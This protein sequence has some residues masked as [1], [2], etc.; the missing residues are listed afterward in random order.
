VLRLVK[1]NWSASTCAQA[2]REFRY[3]AGYELRSRYRVSTDLCVVRIQ[4]ARLDMIY[5]ICNKI[6]HVMYPID[7]TICRD[8]RRYRDV[9]LRPFPATI[10]VQPIHLPAPCSVQAGWIRNYLLELS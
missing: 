10:Y 1:V 6:L 3:G 2:R 5:H 4:T 8:P 9:Q 7:Y